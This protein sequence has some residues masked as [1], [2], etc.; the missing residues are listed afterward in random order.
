M[1]I[2]ITI[3]ITSF[4]IIIIIIMRNNRI[5]IMGKVEI[6]DGILKLE[7][8]VIKQLNKK[9]R[10]TSTRRT[11]ADPTNQRRKKDIYTLIF[12]LVRLVKKSCSSP[13]KLVICNDRHLKSLK[14]AKIRCCRLSSW[15]H[16]EKTMRLNQKGKKTTQTKDD[17]CSLKPFLNFPFNK[18][19]IMTDFFAKLRSRKTTAKK[20]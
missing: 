5:N 12:Y 19:W 15:T 14:G 4:I 20:Y 16:R 13:S 7:E 18:K 10:E 6:L 11:K 9:K 8:L 3:I 1:M 2:V 17:F